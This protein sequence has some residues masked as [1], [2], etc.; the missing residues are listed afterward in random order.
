MQ[1]KLKTLGIIL[2][3]E[4]TININ[5]ILDAIRH[6]PLIGK[7]ISEKIYG[8]RVLKILALILSVNIEI[9]KAFWKPVLWFGALFVATQMI[10]Q[11][12]PD[13]KGT[14]FLT[15]FIW[16]LIV[17]SVF[18]NIFNITTETKYTVFIMGMDAKEYIKARLLYKIFALLL[19]YI[20]FGIP[21]ALLAGVKW[22]LALLIPL[23]GIGVKA[24]VVAYRMLVYSARVTI[25]K[26]S[27]KGRSVTVGGNETLSAMLMIVL[28]IAGIAASI[29]IVYN[30]YSLPVFIAHLVA[31][32]LNV[33][34]FLIINAFSGGIYRTALFAEQEKNERIQIK[35]KKAKKKEVKIGKA[36]E[37]RTGAKGF[38]YLNEL[39]FKRHA[40]AFAG[41]LVVSIVAML[42]ITALAG[43]L[44]YYEVVRHG[45][46]GD[47]VVR[48]V[49]ARHPGVFPLTVFLV[50][51]G[52]S[53]CRAMYANCD[54]AFLMYGFYKT[55]KA[56]LKMF[57]IRMGA[58]V[59]YNIVPPVILAV[60]SVFTLAFTGGED[61]PLQYLFT[62]AQIFVF[63]VLSSVRHLAL[64]YI[65]QPYNS[66]YL[67]KS[68]LYGLLSFIVGTILFV[69]VFIPVNA[70]VLTVVGL[71]LLTVYL[72]VSQ[73]LVY[74]FGPKTFRVK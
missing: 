43:L 18:Y 20:L 1:K 71:I 45:V 44:L 33:P 56:L 32:A 8:I 11:G 21:T 6:L 16:M 4:N 73:S 69:L 39:F 51:I 19:G 37:I 10:G 25:G 59:R 50:N 55:P 27:K 68:K 53:I 58:I 9:I 7:H 47:S 26:K 17:S 36:E 2:S 67:V 41:R 14:I 3:V 34:G 57:R 74:K 65:L 49:V 38:K 30:G 46:T 15:G 22:Y 5:S 29:Y 42:L 63:S 64:Y 40:N 35:T 52:A 72:I 28:G 31:A 23:S 54:S 61:Y 60:F 12:Y 13:F 66:D 70:L 48:Y 24:G 62:A